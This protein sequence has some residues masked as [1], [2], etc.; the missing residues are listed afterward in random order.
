MVRRLS[1]LWRVALAL[2][3]LAALAWP[4]HAQVVGQIQ[5]TVTDAQG[6]VLPGVSLTL[7]N[8]E[9][10]AART[11]VTESDG[12]Y[13]F[14]GLQPGTY[15]LKAELQGFA[16]I[17]VERLTITI[18]LQ[19]QQDLK[20]QVQ[21]LQETVTVTG[22]APVIEVT[23]TEVAQVITQEQIDTL[24][25]ADRQ[26]A[27]LVLLLPGTNMDNTQVRRA[28]ANIGAGGINN[29]MN[30]Y[31]LDGSS[32]WSTNS[33]Q[34]H[35]E[36]P[37]LAIREFRV[38]VAQ[39]SA[40]HGGNVAGLVSIV[41]RSGTNRFSGEALEYFKNQNLQA[42]DKNAE[43]V[44]APKPD[45][46]RNQWGL[47][48]GG[49]VVK[50]KV[51]FYAA[52]E[53][54]TENKSFAVNTGQP[55]FYS[56]L[57][58]VFPT[59]YLRHKYFAR[60][61]WQISQSQ[62][63]FVRYGRDFEHIDCEA[64]GGINAAFSQTYVES[65]RDTTVS[66]HTWV[67][68]NRALN[69]LRVQYPARLWNA[70]GPPGTPV[71][72]R[73]GEFPPERFEGYTQVYQF[74]SLRWGSAASSLN[75]TKRF[76]IKDDYSYS[77]GS[78]Q[79]KFGFGYERYISPEDVVAN[80]GTWTFAADQFF[81]GTPGAIAALRNPA[82]FTASFPSTVRKLRNYWLNGY[83]QDEWKPISNL[84]LNL[85]L[86]YDTQYHSFN[87]QLDFTGREVLKQLINPTSRHDNN[88]V[89]PR[90]G[91]AWD[92]R[93]DTKTL[94]RAAYGRF[95][96]YLPQ[97]SLRNE[98][99]TLLQNS[100][101]INNPPYPDPY[102]GLS[103]QAFVTVSARPNVNILDDKIQNMTGDT[104]TGGV[105]RQLIQNLALHVDGVYTNLRHFSRT[106]NINQPR[107]AFD[108][109]TLDAATAAR[110]AAF[111]A[112]QLNAARPM[113]TW[114][115]VTQLAANGWSDY[116]AIYVRL[117]K[118][119][120]NR[121]MYLISYTRDW[122]T[123]S[124]DAVSDFYH[125]DLDT[126]PSGRKHSLVASGTARLPYDITFGA[127]WTVRTALPYSALS[128][129]DFTGD[130]TVDFVPG[131]SRNQAGRDSKNT[132]YVLQKVNEWRAVRNLAPIP[133]SQLQSSDFNRF[134][135]RVSRAI[136][137]G[138]GR[139]VDLV[140]QV[141]NVFGR[142]NLVGGTGGTF[143]N[144][145]TSNAFGKYGVAGPRQEA[146]VGISFKF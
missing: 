87:N 146:E 134:D 4:A 118:R 70:N 89:G 114:G 88:N 40:E 122:T 102:G 71:W 113:A 120:A 85:G 90:V 121:Y 125:P 62:A 49:P 137:L 112:A 45:Y 140:A 93:N 51:H 26:P 67:I 128:G 74:P 60:G 42:R 72:E 130:G 12:V 126:G 50:D 135:I 117:D 16:T 116:R 98:L 46:K 105:S 139:S 23:R 92:V 9:T 108:F 61:D 52:I 136:V 142:D 32:N 97:G 8:T 55:Q 81:D 63:V 27:S 44:G 25:M 76:E 31:F 84:T 99:G 111:S 107:P 64:C 75:F 41:T 30:A 37:Q 59:D 96:Q 101:V 3:L 77:A 115:N 106:Q 91:L 109:T 94:L 36:M 144:I 79:W 47:A 123:N 80:I 56:K 48:F 35:A 5:G 18:G 19:L 34:Q 73:P 95:Y 22:E 132:A 54:Q 11:T 138:G 69:E 53:Y 104:V 6:G 131:T 103:P 20:M 29:Q 28:Q 83:A 100:I 133:A 13:R 24:P 82:S 2:A 17:D 141:F 129:V 78:H 66:G 143:V 124:V 38:N 58:G 21:N 14:A 86:R 57:E 68:S 145:A 1:S 127:V 33:G 43:D 39:A 110:I 119:M 10:G 15:A 65:P 7:R